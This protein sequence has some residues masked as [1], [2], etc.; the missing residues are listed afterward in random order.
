MNWKKYNQLTRTQQQEYNYTFGDKEHK[1]FMH[2]LIAT[3]F[4]ISVIAFDAI[5]ALNFYENEKFGVGY[6]IDDKY[7]MDNSTVNEIGL[8]NIYEVNS[9][10]VPVAIIILLYAIIRLIYYYIKETIWVNKQ[11]KK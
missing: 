8:K 9:R 1:F 7:G 5:I 2:I 11:F 6:N 3:I 10:F 4:L